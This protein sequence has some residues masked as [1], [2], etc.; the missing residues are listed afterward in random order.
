MKRAMFKKFIYKTIN[1]KL[2]RDTVT[3]TMS[4]AL[5]SQR[6]AGY[7]TYEQKRTEGRDKIEKKKLP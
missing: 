3:V 1:M 6:K 5:F 2:S 4:H 7:E